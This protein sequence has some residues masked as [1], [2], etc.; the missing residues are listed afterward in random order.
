MLATTD[1]EI[2][3][4]LGEEAH[5][6]LNEVQQFVGVSDE[7]ELSASKFGKPRKDTLSGWLAHVCRIVI[8]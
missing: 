1:R 2:L 5:T 4:S 3:E 7:N 6:W 8:R